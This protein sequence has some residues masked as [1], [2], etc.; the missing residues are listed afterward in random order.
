MK[1]DKHIHPHV[2][3]PSQNI[4][5]SITP[6][7]FLVPPFQAIVQLATVLIFTTLDQL[8]LGLHVI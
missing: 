5:I 7:V 4:E 8:I 3:L 1:L 2:H 6:E